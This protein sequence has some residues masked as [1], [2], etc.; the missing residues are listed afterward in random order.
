MYCKFFG[1]SEKPFDITPRPEFLYPTPGHTEALA[2][3]VYGIR[4]RRGFVVMV[5]DIGTGKT[6][7]LLATM[8][9]LPKEIRSVLL[10]NSE[11]P[12][13]QLLL[14]ML[15]ELG[16]L[17]EGESLSNLLALKRLYKFAIQ[18]FAGGGNLVIFIDEA[19]NFNQHTLENFR[20]LSNLESR[21]HKLIQFV[22]AGQPELDI[23]LNAYGLRPFV[24]RI[25]LKRYIK[26]LSK[27]DTYKYLQHCLAKA[28]Y[29][30]PPIFNN[31]AQQLIWEFSQ[32]VPRRINILCDN[33]LL[34]A[35]ARNKTK[36]KTTVMKEAINDLSYSPYVKTAKIRKLMF[37]WKKAVTA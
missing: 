30:G 28:K 8:L 13:E 19:Q 35:Y 5:G 14:M 17:R 4:E 3:L 34:I 27:K 11:M 6:T 36:I 16:L 23:K 31:R 24:Q 10:F 1:F 22:L 29:S 21:K 32:G 12:F 7:L 18:L 25:S 15:D 9:K 20:I 2:S 26:P 37:P 33:A